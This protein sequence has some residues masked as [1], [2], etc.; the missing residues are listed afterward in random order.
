MGHLA[1]KQIKHL[2]MQQRV[3]YDDTF[4]YLHLYSIN[5]I[6]NTQT[7][8]IYSNHTLICPFYVDKNM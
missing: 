8:N 5:N 2:T 3:L 7:I 6:R 4:L 1:V